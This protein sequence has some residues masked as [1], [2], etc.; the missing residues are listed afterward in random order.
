MQHGT[1]APCT[2]LCRTLQYADMTTHEGTI[3]TVARRI[4]IITLILAG[5]GLL[6]LHALPTPQLHATTGAHIPYQP[7]NFLSEFVR[8]DYAPLMIACFFLLALGAM[9]TAVTLRRLR[10]EAILVAIAGIALGLLG[11]F[12]TDLSDLT[13]D[14]FTCGSAD[15]VEPCTVTGLIHNPL[16]TMVFLPL[17]LTALSVCARSFKEPHWRGIAYLA[18][19][20][21]VVAVG[22]IVG[23]T[24]YLQSLGWE[25][26]WWTGLMQRSLVFP[27]LLWMGG[28]LIVTKN[29]PLRGTGMTDL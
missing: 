29:L 16:S 9:A 3:E 2:P 23:A 7:V 5:I 22:G 11:V 21:G 26:R 17:L 15:R 20:C 4:G 25:G 27:A 28:L 14:R 8:T 19:G 13:T 10:R 6:V 18:V 1:F 12:P 24:F